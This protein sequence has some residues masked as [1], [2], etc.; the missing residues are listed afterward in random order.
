MAARKRTSP[1][2]G[3]C[4]R[5]RHDRRGVVYTLTKGRSTGVPEGIHMNGGSV[6]KSTIPCRGASDVKRSPFKKPRNVCPRFN[7]SPAQR[8]SRARALLTKTKSSTK[9]RASSLRSDLNVFVLPGDLMNLSSGLAASLVGL[10][11]PEVRSAGAR[12]TRISKVASDSAR[13]QAHW[14]I[15]GTLPAARAPSPRRPDPEPYNSKTVHPAGVLMH[16]NS[17]HFGGR[18]YGSHV[19][20]PRR[21]TTLPIVVG[22]ASTRSLRG[23]RK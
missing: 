22:R 10:A 11:F 16:G 2:R 21:R 19:L 4:L 1:K 9:A 7:A 6:N 20:E 3:D 18:G 5:W 8:P 14:A 23:P 17:R 15:S 13:L 12:R